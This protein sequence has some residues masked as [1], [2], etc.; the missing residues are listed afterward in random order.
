MATMTSPRRPG[1]IVPVTRPTFP[2]ISWSDTSE[3]SSIKGNAPP[4]T[5]GRVVGRRQPGLTGGAWRYARRGCGAGAGRG[6][7]GR[8][9]GGGG[10]RRG[11][12]ARGPRR[13]ALV[14][15]GQRQRHDDDAHRYSENEGGSAP[16]QTQEGGVHGT[17]ILEER[18]PPAAAGSAERTLSGV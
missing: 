18:T 3:P 8:G 14:A 11:R 2:S 15:K 4:T 7:D 5:A 10:G 6:R 9:R 1:A 12:R 17:A 13:G 16:F